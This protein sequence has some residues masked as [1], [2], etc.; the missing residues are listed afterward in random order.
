MSC[1]H[2]GE[3]VLVQQVGGHHLDPVEQVLDPLVAVVAGAAH[4]ADHLVALGE[5]QLREVGAVLAGDPG[6][7][8]FRHDERRVEVVSSGWAR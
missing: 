8:R 5:Q 4:H 1:K 3:R 6:D 2:D 7:E